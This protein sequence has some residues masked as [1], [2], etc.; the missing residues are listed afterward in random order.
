MSEAK[1]RVRHDQD[2]MVL[3]AHTGDDVGLRMTGPINAS[4][5]NDV[6]KAQRIIARIIFSVLQFLLQT[7]NDDRARP[8]ANS[9]WHSVRATSINDHAELPDEVGDWLYSH[10]MILDDPFSMLQ[11]DIGPNGGFAQMWLLERIMTDGHLWVGNYVAIDKYG[12]EDEKEDPEEVEEK[13]KERSPEPLSSNGTISEVRSILE[14]VKSYDNKGKGKEVAHSSHTT[15]ED[16]EAESDKSDPANQSILQRQAS[17]KI[18]AMMAGIAKFGQGSESF[19]TSIDRRNIAMLAVMASQL[20]KNE[21]P[22]PGTE[23]KR[24]KNLF[25][26]LDVDEP[27]LVGIPH[28]GEWETLPR[29]EVRSMSICCVVNM[30]NYDSSSQELTEIKPDA[31]FRVRDKVRGMFQLIDDMPNRFEFI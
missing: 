26:V 8:I 7:E 14:T 17:R 20:E 4:I 18:L 21:L 12:N 29:P 10:P 5:V 31:Q 28:C 6:P 22:G 11:L 15:E 19:K 16:E 2:A 23:R 3:A 13:T 9:I 24:S 27:C 30:T 1:L 25:A